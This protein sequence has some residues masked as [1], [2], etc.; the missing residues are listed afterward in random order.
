MND[1]ATT[2]DPELGE[3]TIVREYDAPR[4]MVFR[5]MVEPEQLAQFW[6]PV[7]IHSPADRMVLEPRVGGRFETVMVAD[8][9]SGEFPTA[10]VFTEFDEPSVLAFAEPDS[11]MI[12]RSTFEDLGNGRTRVTIHQTNVPEMFR[13][14]E[15]L[16]GFETS[17]DRFAAYL[18]QL[19]A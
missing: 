19:Q 16:A 18:A 15:A 17:L 5:A 1:T 8:D 3:V 11:D 13:S 6:G 4:E 14:P 9:G 2:V 10:A 12:T 7:G